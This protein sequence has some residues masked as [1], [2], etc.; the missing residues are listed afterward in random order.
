MN[1]AINSEDC[2][3]FVLKCCTTLKNIL[4]EFRVMKPL[5]R[6]PREMVDAPSLQTFKFRLDGALRN[7]I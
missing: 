7:L 3:Q 5:K 2:E 6:V 1:K 4:Y